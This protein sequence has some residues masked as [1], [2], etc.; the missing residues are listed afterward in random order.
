MNAAYYAS[1]IDEYVKTELSSMDLKWGYKC[2]KLRRRD[3]EC[4]V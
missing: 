2:S 4:A 1:V 3:G